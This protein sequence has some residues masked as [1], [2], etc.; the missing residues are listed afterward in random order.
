MCCFEAIDRAGRLEDREGMAGER[1][2]SRGRRRKR[3]QGRHRKRKRDKPSCRVTSQEREPSVVGRSAGPQRPH[4]PERPYWNK[5]PDCWQWVDGGMLALEQH[6]RSSNLCI[7][8]RC[9]SHDHL[10]PWAECLRTAEKAL[11]NEQWN[12]DCPPPRSDTAAGSKAHFQATEP[13]KL[14]DKKKKEKAKRTKS[15]KARAKSLS[16]RVGKLRKYRSP[17]ADSSEGTQVKFG[18]QSLIIRLS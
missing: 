17:S 13:V 15:R 11:R 6:Q 14:K 10:R 9:W 1:S 3:S 8:W 7:A 18:G 12:D 4:S 5:C 2:R 16:P